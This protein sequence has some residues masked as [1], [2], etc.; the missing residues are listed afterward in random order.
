MLV[1]LRTLKKFPIVRNRPSSFI[2]I[3]V[4]VLAVP[5]SA[6]ATDPKE[7][8]KNENAQQENTS[9]E[10]SVAIYEEDTKLNDSHYDYTPIVPSAN[11]A[12]ISGT[13][14]YKPYV[15]KFQ[16]NEKLEAEVDPNSAMSFNFIYY[17]IDKFKFT[18]PLD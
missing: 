11:D 17:I 18:D 15:P 12:M 5:F 3:A 16:E 9:K 4:I 6:F 10:D 13:T 2:L 7:A 1:Y 8:D 14:E